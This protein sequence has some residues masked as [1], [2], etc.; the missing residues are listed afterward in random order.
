MSRGLLSLLIVLSVAGAGRA[1]LD[2]AAPVVPL[3]DVRSGTTVTHRFPLVNRSNVD[4]VITDVR[5]DCGCTVA[6]LEKRRLKPGEETSLGILV[7]TLTQAAG[8]QSWPTRVTFRCGDDSGER[9]LTLTGTIVP[10]VSVEPAGLGIYTESSV[11]RE[12]TLLDRRREPLAI[13]VVYTTSPKLRAVQSEPRRDGEGHTIY[14]IQLDVAA[15]FPEGRHDETL[16]I[17]T[18][19]PDFRELKVPVKV[20][21]KQRLT[22]SATPDCVT[23]TAAQGQPLPSCLVRLRG[24]DD[25]AI[26]IERIETDHP[27]LHCTW[28]MGPYNMATIK[29]SFDRAKIDGDNLQTAIHVHLSKPAAQTLTIPVTATQR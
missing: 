13:S 25:E 20:V 7:S 4:L 9:T 2:C 27:A 22:V 6:K 24:P 18:T 28:A 5:T 26:Q 1:Q 3:G 19:D 29:I 10:T 16:F 14:T 23:A 8:P 17:Y 15:D 21:K 12:V 11:R